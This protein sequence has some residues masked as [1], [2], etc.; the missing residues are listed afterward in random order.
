MEITYSITVN[1]CQK[2][3]PIS[4]HLFFIIFLLVKERKK[5]T[6]CELQRGPKTPP[7]VLK[8]DIRNSF[9]KS[10]DQSFTSPLI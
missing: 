7:D 6:S 8:G 5:K 10:Y 4:L 1:F 9:F 3:V 2:Q